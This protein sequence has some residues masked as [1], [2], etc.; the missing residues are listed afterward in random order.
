METKQ[1]VR[2]G[3]FTLD[4]VAGL[5]NTTNP[6]DFTDGIDPLPVVIL[7]GANG[8]GKTTLLDAILDM[9]SING[10]S[11]LYPTDIPEADEDITIT[12][13]FKRYIDKIIYTE[14]VKV[15]VAYERLNSDLK[16]ICD[17]IDVQFFTID[18]V[19]DK[20]HDHYD[21]KQT[22]KTI[23][24]TPRGV[25]EYRD[26]SSGLK[27]YLINVSYMKLI[28]FRDGIILLDNPDCGLH[29]AVQKEMI[30]IYKKYARD[31]NCQIIIST[32]SPFIVDDNWDC[33]R[34]LVLDGSDSVTVE[35]FTC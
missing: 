18:V 4:Q 29:I 12:A 19:V 5:K 10:T 3:L 35:K 31:N 11:V 13:A 22:L 2:L 30:K 34:C 21:E 33:V 23:F 8:V 17:N 9:C 7:T 27:K 24:D 1:N 20:D 6:I 16:E 14:D 25:R 28:G 26:L 15:S 32:H